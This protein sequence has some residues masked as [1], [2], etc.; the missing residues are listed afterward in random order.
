M[1]ATKFAW[2]FDANG[3]QIGLEQSPRAHQTGGRGS[4]KRLRVDAIDLYY[5]HRVDPNVPIEEVAGAVKELVQQG[6]VKHSASPNAGV[7]TIRRAHAVLPVTA[8]QSDIRS[9][10]KPE[11]ELL[12]ALEELGI[13]FVPFSPLGRGFLTGKIDEK[14]EFAANDF[15]S[16]LPRFAPESRKNR[17]LVDFLGVMLA[18]KTRRRRKSRLRGSSRRVVRSQDD[19]T[20][21]PTRGDAGIELTAA[22]ICNA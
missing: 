8:V 1:I 10:R 12:P 2:E 14:T 13:G 16:I 18:Q 22:D 17:A 19:A 11:A 5:Q 21:T 4:L 6:K 3:K 15:R 20:R 9:W 7:N